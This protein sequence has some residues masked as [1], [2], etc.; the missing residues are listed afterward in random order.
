M[1]Y[2]W[3]AINAAQSCANQLKQYRVQIQV[4]LLSNTFSLECHSDLA[5]NDAAIGNYDQ[6]PYN[7]HASKDTITLRTAS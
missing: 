6:Q 4:T 7:W 5:H 1:S 2:I 3:E